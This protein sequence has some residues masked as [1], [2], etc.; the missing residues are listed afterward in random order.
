M[1]FVISG[2]N[3]FGHFLLTQELLPLL[4]QAAKSAEVASIVSVSSVG[5]YA[6]YPEG[7]LGSIEEMNNEKRYSDLKAYCQSKL[8]N[9]LFTQELASRVKEDNVLVNCIH[10][11]IHLCELLSAI[12]RLTC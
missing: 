2:V 7:I 4:K 3:H 9:V 10:P 11:G 6:S 1:C 5:H 8:A 12:V